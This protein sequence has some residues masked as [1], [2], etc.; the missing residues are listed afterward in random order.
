MHRS[1]PHTMVY[2][3]RYTGQSIVQSN[4]GSYIDGPTL[5][6]LEV[7]R[8]AR[9]EKRREALDIHDRFVI[10]GSFYDK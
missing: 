9:L 6:M 5:D 2:R 10:G 3:P 4:R 1:I 8:Y 7:E